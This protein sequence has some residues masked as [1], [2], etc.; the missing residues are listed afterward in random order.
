MSVGD[1]SVFAG[2]FGLGVNYWPRHAG[3]RMWERFD[4]PGMSAELAAMRGLGID[5]VRFFALVPSFMPRPPKID[6]VMVARFA[7]LCALGSAAG[8]ALFP[9]PL[10]GHMSGQNFDLP[11]RDNRSLWRDPEMV[12]WQAALVDAL[13]AAAPS[14]GVHWV[15][16]NELPLWAGMP[17]RS[18]VPAV[19]A[20]VERLSRAAK[21]R[22]HSV[23]LG[24]GAMSE[25]P[26]AEVAP[27]VD[28][29]GP[30]IYY[31]DLCPARQA[32]FVDF[33]LRR[34]AGLGRPLVL[35]EFGCSSVQAGEAE[36]AAYFR[37]TVLS[38]FALG[39]RGAFAW[40]WSDFDASTIGA[41]EPYVHHPFELG[42]G[43]LRADGSEKPVCAE[44]R[45]LGGLFRG[46]DLRC[47]APPPS[48][49]VL[50]VPRVVEHPD[51]VPFSWQDAGRARR[52]LLAAY[53]LA[54]QAGLDPEVLVEPL[55]I[56]DDFLARFD[57]VLC[58]ATQKLRVPT[59]LALEQAA[60][61]GATVYWS[62]FGGDHGFHQGAWCPNFGPLT[63]LE[64]RL[65]YGCFDLPPPVV[66]LRGEVRLQI[67][68]SI[69]RCA[70]DDAYQLARLPIASE[71]SQVRIVARD[72]TGAPSLAEHALGQGRVVFAN[73]PFERYRALEGEVVPDGLVEL[74]R[75][76]G[77]RLPTAIVGD[78]DVEVRRVVTAA[79]TLLVVQN[80]GWRSA[81]LP[82]LP[83]NVQLVYT[84]QPRDGTS[85]EQQLS[86]KGARVYRLG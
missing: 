69:D 46:L 53:T 72:A 38:A 79:D 1:G 86:P 12:A 73:H 68:T 61:R 58:P 30:H 71:T 54:C 63:G 47:H 7:R 48:R 15:L 49:T 10:V 37:E 40:C 19:R 51:E 52:T 78:P 4:E 29:L 57:L 85:D 39:A 60:R 45:A 23:G 24:D 17:A 28:W 22:G 33:T 84:S 16:S 42:F 70:Y 14:E 20:L 32:H 41:E 44:L 35:E 75:W 43:V 26:S 6:P 66:E 65:R 81:S 80:R 27:L 2:R 34:L 74:Y 5:A 77:T 82:N 76:L 67:Q 31:A 50:L 13:V 56:D 36:Q 62:Y 25:F 59:W 3:P 21:K 55:A 83:P 18:E 11:G 64:H 8:L 9:T